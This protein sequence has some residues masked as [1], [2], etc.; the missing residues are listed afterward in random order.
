MEKQHLQQLVDACIGDGVVVN[1]QVSIILT[2]EHFVASEILFNQMTYNFLS[3]NEII[4]FR[5]LNFLKKWKDLCKTAFDVSTPL[6]TMMVDFQNTLRKLQPNLLKVLVPQHLS[7]SDG[8]TIITTFASCFPLQS[9]PPD[10]VAAYLTL[11]DFE[12]ISK[13]DSKE[14]LKLRWLDPNQ[15]PTLR[16]CSDRID[17]LARWTTYKILS[18]PDKFR[19]K[20]LDYFLRVCDC[21]LT[22]QN[23][24]SIFGLFLGLLKINE[25]GLSFLWKNVKCF[26]LV[27]KFKTL[28]DF[29]NNFNSYR[30][31]IRNLEFPLIE[32]QEIVLK[33]LLILSESLP[34]KLDD[35]SINMEKM[36][37]MG[38]IIQ[39][40]FIFYL[41][42]L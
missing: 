30:S 10:S 40:A 5:I 4:Q 32:F 7:E 31:H 20:I 19:V 24:N 16:N 9:F 37:H 18:A 14:L 34:D 38:K 1:V 3:L 33:D 25:F 12:L 21:L 2:H 8:E 27:V 35:G 29:G 15:A 28:C 36:L 26:E 22:Y 17:R 39:V 42:L 13:V 23:F 41:V 6:G 11:K